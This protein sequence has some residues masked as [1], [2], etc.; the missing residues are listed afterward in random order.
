MTGP[1]PK[2]QT[3]VPRPTIPP[4]KKQIR[5]QTTSWTSG[6]EVRGCACVCHDQGQGV[7]GGYAYVGLGY[8]ERPKLHTTTPIRTHRTHLPHLAGWDRPALKVL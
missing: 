2:A 8:M 3:I 1:R 7:V 6:T 4:L 5:A